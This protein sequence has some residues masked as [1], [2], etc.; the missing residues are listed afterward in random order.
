MKLSLNIS[1]RLYAALLLNQFKGNLDTLVEIM[2]DVKKFRITDEEWTK[3]DRQINTTMDGN[4]NP[5][6]SWAWNDDKGGDKEIEITKT[7]KE[8][9]VGKI[10]E[11]NDKGQ[12]TFQDKAAITLSNKLGQEK[13][14][15]EE[16]V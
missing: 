12:F 8:Y 11:A 7:T 3:A 2:D 10:K 9:L 6:T 5:I 16:K 15:K 14:G 4:S 1:E 13:K